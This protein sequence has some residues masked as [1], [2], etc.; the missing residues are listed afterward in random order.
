[1]STGA[2]ILFEEEAGIATADKK[3]EPGAATEKAKAAVP[4]KDDEELEVIVLAEEIVAH[5]NPRKCINCGTCRELC[6]VSAIEENQRAICRICPSC[7]E[8]PAVTVN[9]MYSLPTEKACTTGCPLGIS[10]QGYVNLTYLGKLDEAYKLI[11]DKNPLPSVCARICH[12]PC[13]SYC[14][15]GILIDRPIAI[16]ALKKYLGEKVDYKPAKYP[17]VYDEKIAVIGAGPAGLTAGHYLSML[18]YEVTV[19]EGGHEAGGMLKRGIPEFRL[20]RS[21]VDKEIANLEAA[22]LEIKLQQNINKYSMNDLKKEYDAVIVATGAP[23]SKELFIE[24]WRL[25]GVMTAMNFM[26]QVNS[27]AAVRRHLGQLFKFEGGEAVIIGGGSVAID[28]ARTALRVGAS[29]VTVVCLESGD[30]VP[31]HPWELEEAKEEGITIIEGY[32]PKRFTCELFPTLSGVEFSKV[33][34]LGQDEFGKFIIETDD[35]DTIVVKADWSVV[36]IGQSPDEFWNEITGRKVF[37]AGDVRSN[38]CSV[39]DAMASGRE[40]AFAVDAQLR[41]R[42]LKDP[43]ANHELHL[44]PLLEKLFSY[45]FRKTARPKLPTVPSAIRVNS[46]TEVEGCF[47]D[48]EAKQ[49]AAA[50]LNC[51]YEVV[52]VEKCLGC[53]ICLKMCPKGDA[54]T[55]VAKPKG[56]K[57]E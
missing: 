13:E 35:E 8:R 40:V 26:E 48:A 49:E 3:V 50:C 14:K 37:F 54:I 11:W 12:H 45:N 27:K 31:A 47:T 38:K 4:A 34:S 56:G 52:D 28:A 44:A 53:G 55:M 15:R 21:I 6:P 9:K 20:D 17:R 1:M 29:K 57:E 41:R 10:P 24:N 33:K 22:G 42:K 39:I 25:A 2:D 7:T 46:F 32:S 18:G 43:K 23:N 19:L 36:A 30:A 51:G 16:R 5:I